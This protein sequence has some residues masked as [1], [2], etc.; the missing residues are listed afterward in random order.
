MLIG[1]DARAAIA[2]ALEVPADQIGVRDPTG[3]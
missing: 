3:F 2:A 1:V